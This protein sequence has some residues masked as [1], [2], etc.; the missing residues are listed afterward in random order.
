MIY[1]RVRKGQVQD[2]CGKFCLIYL[3]ALKYLVFWI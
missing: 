1:L 3:V 2:R